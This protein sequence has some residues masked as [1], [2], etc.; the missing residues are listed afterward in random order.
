MLPMLLPVSALALST[1][2][3]LFWRSSYDVPSPVVVEE[4]QTNRL[5]QAYN[6]ALDAHRF[7]DALAAANNLSSTTAQGQA[8]LAA[9][10][11]SAL[12]SLKRDDEARRQ[13]AKAHELDPTSSG[14]GFRTVV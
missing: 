11:A 6:D 12:F 8:Q 10:R 4:D 1:A 7:E 5:V 2:G 14:P 13:I 3:P 9:M